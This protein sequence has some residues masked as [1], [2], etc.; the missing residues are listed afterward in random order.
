MGRLSNAQLF[1]GLGIDLA[2]Y[3]A[4][5]SWRR[6]EPE[7]I[8]VDFDDLSTD[9]YFLLSGEVRVLMGQDR[10][11]RPEARV[12]FRG[13]A[14]RPRRRTRPAL[15]RPGP[16]GRRHQA[17]RYAHGRSSAGRTASQPCR[18]GPHPDSPALLRHSP[19][20]DARGD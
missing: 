9:V 14:P 19:A 3:E 10:P 17:R 2:P 1:E 4:R 8:L 6:F 11:A 16:G 5:A 15:A 7:E 13:R 18:F 20:P 12:P